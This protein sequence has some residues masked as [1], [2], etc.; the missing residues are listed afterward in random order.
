MRYLLWIVIIVLLS[1]RIFLFYH[2]QPKYPEGTKLRISSRVTSEPI[3]YSNSQYLKLTGLKLYLPLYPEVSYGDRVVVEG[4]VENGKV[5]DAVLIKVTE[6][7]GVIYKFRQKLITFYK[8]A[9]PQPHSSLIAGVA[10]G[11]K[12]EI[13]RDFWEKLKKSGTAHVVVASGMNV[14][15]IGAFLMG[16]LIVVLPRKRAI[17]FAIAGIWSYALLS[18]FDAPIIR[19]AVMGSIAFSAQELGRLNATVRA[20]VITALAMVSIKPD[21]IGDTG[22]LLSFTATLSIILFESKLYK[23]LNF[24]PERFKA[25]KKDFST[26]LS[27]SIGVTPVLYLSFGQFNII[28][29]LINMLVLWTIV[30]VTLIGMMG[31]ILGIVY[32]PIGTLILW[33]AYPLTSWFIL[34]INLM[35]N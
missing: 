35:T 5:R 4:K 30:P 26:S 22:F 9:L 28:S 7:S 12:S 14:S 15:L 29:P 17:P 19:A 31:G 2:N 10:I 8:K 25:F 21:W 34:I 3:R 18:G 6:S 24:I 13:P 16:I 1:V 23:L 33:L 27:A 32:E 20:L 11:S